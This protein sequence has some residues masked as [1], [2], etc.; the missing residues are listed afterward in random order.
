MSQLL[1]LKD[2]KGGVGTF[3][4]KE[5]ISALRRWSEMATSTAV[6]T[7]LYGTLEIA[8][9]T[10]SW[11]MEIADAGAEAGADA[12]ASA[13]VGVRLGG[14]ETAEGRSRSRC[15]CCRYIM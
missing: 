7:A 2:E 5:H 3:W 9:S 11:P 12:D 15:G 8:G 6:K 10:V 4:A 1:R 14:V 13:G